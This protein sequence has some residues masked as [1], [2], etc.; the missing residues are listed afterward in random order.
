MVGYFFC[1]YLYH[2]TKTNHL[3]SNKYNTYMA[4]VDKE[5]TMK[6]TTQPKRYWC[7]DISQTLKEITSSKKN[8]KTLEKDGI[9]YEYVGDDMVL[10]TKT[11]R[12]E[13]I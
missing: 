5:S 2:E 13:K 8:G 11:N 3:G 1:V 7:E 10:N 6:K 12:L 9:I 4:Q